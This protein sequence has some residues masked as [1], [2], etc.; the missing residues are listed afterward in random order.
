MRKFIPIVL[1]L[2]FVLSV[3]GCSMAQ[4]SEERD[5]QARDIIG[6]QLKDAWQAETG[7]AVSTDPRLVNRDGMSE[8]HS[9]MASMILMGQGMDPD[10]S[11]YSSDVYLV[12]FKDAAGV[13]RAAVY[14]NNKIV[15]P[16]NAGE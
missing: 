13:E 16:A 3:M 12:E 9:V 10:L 7:E 14:V 5:E 6:S 1:V 11:T 2:L 4:Y 15:L 8:S